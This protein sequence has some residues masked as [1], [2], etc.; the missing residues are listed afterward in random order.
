MPPYLK[1]EEVEEVE[2][3][4]KQSDKYNYETERNNGKK[5]LVD[6]V[7]CAQR[8]PCQIA[9]QQA[10]LIP[11]CNEPHDKKKAAA[12]LPSSRLAAKVVLEKLNC[13]IPTA[14]ALLM[15]DLFPRLLTAN[16]PLSKPRA[17]QTAHPVAQ[18]MSM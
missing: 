16:P 7:G 8:I 3:V 14:V 18:K 13:A 5:L 2:E 6:T 17:K 11:S 1:V 4:E 12:A 9:R 10:N 15:S